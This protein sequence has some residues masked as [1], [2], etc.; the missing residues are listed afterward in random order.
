MRT[1]TVAAWIFVGFGLLMI[2]LWLHLFHVSGKLGI[3][4]AVLGLIYF[5]IGWV[6]ATMHGKHMQAHAGGARMNAIKEKG[7]SG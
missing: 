4:L 1:G 6:L 7:A 5:D 2:G 3:F